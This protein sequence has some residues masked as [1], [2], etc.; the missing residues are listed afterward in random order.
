MLGTMQDL[1]V[2]VVEKNRELEEQLSDVV[3][4]RGA[5]MSRLQHSIIP[6]RVERL[7]RQRA[8]VELALQSLE[9]ELSSRITSI[10]QQHE[11]SLEPPKA[12]LVKQGIVESDFYFKAVPSLF[13]TQCGAA[14]NTMQGER[15]ALQLNCATVS[16]LFFPLL[17]NPFLNLPT[18]TRM[19]TQ[20]RPARSDSK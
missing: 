18:L 19:S 13:E 4:Q 8:A 10:F 5:L 1:R 12:R 3:T 17:G 2:D 15:L 9:L 20:P 14:V 16:F 11:A 7:A 6:D